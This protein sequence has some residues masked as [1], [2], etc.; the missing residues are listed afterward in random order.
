M[1]FC[2]GLVSHLSRCYFSTSKEKKA[3]ESKDPFE[4][5]R[6]CSLCIFGQNLPCGLANVG[7]VRTIMRLQQTMK[8]HARLLTVYLTPTEMPSATR[9]GL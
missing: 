4:A 7:K 1:V 8:A 2:L 5:E 3:E 6:D 9:L